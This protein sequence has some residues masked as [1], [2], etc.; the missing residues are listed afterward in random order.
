MALKKVPPTPRKPLDPGRLVE[1]MNLDIPIGLAKRPYYHWEQ[2]RHRNPPGEYTVEEWWSMC[3]VNR[4]IVSHE[5]PMTSESGDHFRYCLTDRIR[6]ALHEIDQKAAGSISASGLPDDDMRLQFLVDGRIVEAITSAQLEGA[7]TGHAVAASMLRSG[8]DPE[9]KDQLMIVNTYLAMNQIAK[10]PDTLT[11]PD[12]CALHEQ[13]T[14]GTLDNELDAGR[15]QTPEEERVCVRDNRSGAILHE[16]PPAKLLPKR[17]KALR[18]FANEAK[19]EKR[20]LHPVLR[21]ITLHFWL[22][23][24][25]PFVDGNGRAA[26]MLYYWLAEKRGFWML[27]YVPISTLLRKQPAKYGMAYQYVESD[28]NDLTYFF[29]YQL[30]VILKMLNEFLE[31][32]RHRTDETN[33]LQH[34]LRSEGFNLRQLALLSHALRNPAATYSAK[35]HSISHNV[36]MPTA[37]TDL[38]RLAEAGYLKTSGRHGKMQLYSRNRAKLKGAG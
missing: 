17:M 27:Q 13:V 36:S 1:L 3:R 9:D 20:F 19:P 31:H 12:I 22:A 15:I 33:R 35:T 8:A 10:M 7:S 38:T 26:R 37:R 18:D 2:L 32:V 24:D 30:D 11:V 21:A 34:R 25:H 28:G 4:G 29:E 16:P 23:Y 14:R 6:R 5:L